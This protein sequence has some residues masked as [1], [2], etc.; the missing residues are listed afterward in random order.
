M[1]ELRCLAAGIGLIC[2]VQGLLYYFYMLS[3]IINSPVAMSAF[4]IIH[5]CNGLFKHSASILLGL[6]LLQMAT[7]SPVNLPNTARSIARYRLPIFLYVQGACMVMDAVL[8]ATI[9][10]VPILAPK[11]LLDIGIGVTLGFSA[12]FLYM[13]SHRHLGG[14]NHHVHDPGLAALPNAMGYAP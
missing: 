3:M 5:L 7:D 10:A 6:A 1:F 2:L 9:L 8:N 4:T 13:F 12:I 11:T 14:P